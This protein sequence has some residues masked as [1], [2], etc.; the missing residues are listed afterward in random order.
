MRCAL[1]CCARCGTHATLQTGYMAAILIAASDG[2]TG[3][4]GMQVTAGCVPRLIALITCGRIAVQASAV[5]AAIVNC[6]RG[7]E[8]LLD[9][10]E[11]LLFVE[12]LD[13][14]DPGLERN[15]LSIIDNACKNSEMR[16]CFVVRMLT[17]QQLACASCV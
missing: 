6:P 15:V 10:G 2:C 5:L 11:A 3:A 14:M 8:A 16:K 13:W 4:C 9:S 7:T 17:A 12:L 1:N